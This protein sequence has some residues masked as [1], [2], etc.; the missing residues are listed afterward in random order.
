MQRL[1]RWFALESKTFPDIRNN[2]R[3]SKKEKSWENDNFE[4]KNENNFGRRF[5]GFAHSSF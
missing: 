1:C 2:S 4:A 3:V 5:P